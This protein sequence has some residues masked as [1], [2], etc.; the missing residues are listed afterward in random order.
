MAV[1]SCS[2]ASLKKPRPTAPNVGMMGM[3][4]V[5]DPLA[6]KGPAK[7][8]VFKASTARGGR[9]EQKFPLGEGQGKSSF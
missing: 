8:V 6:P 1:G 5:G 2:P 3:M 7:G 4:V 9:L